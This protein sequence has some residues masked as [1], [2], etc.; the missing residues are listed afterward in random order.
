MCVYWC[1]SHS[2]FAFYGNVHSCTTF[3]VQLRD[4]CVILVNISCLKSISI[5]PIYLCNVT[6]SYK[7]RPYTTRVVEI[8][9][10]RSTVSNIKYLYK[11]Y[12]TLNIPCFTPL[13]LVVTTCSVLQRRFNHNKPFV[14][15]IPNFVFD[16]CVA[17]E[18]TVLSLVEKLLFANWNISYKLQ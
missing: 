5:W 9:P 10:E 2:T 8:D 12:L 4:I 6:F 11:F 16:S 18:L 17:S 1:I 14:T 13:F 15:H 7:E 3:M